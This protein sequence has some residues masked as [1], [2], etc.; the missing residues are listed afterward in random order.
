MVHGARAWYSLANF[1]GQEVKDQRHTRP[2]LETLGGIILEP[3]DVE[4]CRDSDGSLKFIENDIIIL[5]T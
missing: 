5:M 3:A 1:W 4:D 2:K